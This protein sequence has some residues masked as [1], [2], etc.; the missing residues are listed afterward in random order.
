[1]KK[2][3]AILLIFA[4]LMA[5]AMAVSM[6]SCSSD[7]EPEVYEVRVVAESHDHQS[8]AM[9]TGSGID[10]EG[11]E[12]LDFTQTLFTT[13]DKSIELSLYC[14]NPQAVLTLKVWVNDELKC[15]T[16]GYSKIK[17]HVYL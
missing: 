14:V 3:N 13:T 5:M 4:G 1:M 17:S 9:L 15:Q 6:G 8:S 10:S 16:R 2:Y 12:F 7:D 11:I